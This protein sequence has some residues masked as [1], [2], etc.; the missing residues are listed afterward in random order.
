MVL[1]SQQRL[2]ATCYTAP[3][4]DLLQTG[5]NVAGTLDKL[6]KLFGERS[7]PDVGTSHSLPHQDFATAV[8][9]MPSELPAE[10]F[11][12]SVGTQWE[13]AIE[14]FG[15]PLHYCQIQWPARDGAV[16]VATR[17][18]FAAVMHNRSR[19]NYQLV[20]RIT[21]TATVQGPLTYPSGVELTVDKDELG[22]YGHHKHVFWAVNSQ[23]FRVIEVVGYS[24]THGS[25]PRMGAW[26]SWGSGGEGYSLRPL[27]FAD[28]PGI[29]IGLGQDSP[30]RLV[31]LGIDPSMSSHVGGTTLQ[32][33][34]EVK[35]ADQAGELSSGFEE[36]TWFKSGTGLVELRQS[37]AGQ[38]TMRW[39]LRHS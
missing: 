16:T 34:R 28:R 7:A 1:T 21:G 30:E 22:F 13:Y 12:T 38:E 35:A 18:R 20:I 6:K 2:A 4:D 8:Q 5:V 32:F 26:G 27:F 14:V 25:A 23:G 36:H 29:A 3:L 10:F 11:P 17:G 9:N 15:D 31:C 37:V 19:R 24:P 39:R 33:V